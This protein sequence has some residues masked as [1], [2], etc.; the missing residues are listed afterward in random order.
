MT[1]QMVVK[2]LRRSE[3]KLTSP[4]QRNSNR[5][6]RK[7][8]WLFPISGS[9]LPNDLSMDS[10]IPG[11][12]SHSDAT[13]IGGASSASSSPY[14]LL[15]FCSWVFAK[16]C[17]RFEVSAD[18]VTKLQMLL[19][20]HELTRGWKKGTNGPGLGTRVSDTASVVKPIRGPSSLGRM[21]KKRTGLMRSFTSGSNNISHRSVSKTAED[22]M[23]GIVNEDKRSVASSPHT[24]HHSG[25]LGR[26]SSRSR[27]RSQKKVCLMDCVNT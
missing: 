27:R 11:S 25:P 9:S 20:V 18:P 13:G 10:S 26:R 14:T 3:R 7:Q 15:A 6:S 12:V 8:S 5:R 21:K 24:L 17:T 1:A 2:G 16:S 4:K 23:L 19:R 22:M